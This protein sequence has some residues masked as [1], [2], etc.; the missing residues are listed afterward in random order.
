MSQQRKFA[1]FALAFMAISYFIA[2]HIERDRRE[3]LE[4]RLEQY[5]KTH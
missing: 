1:I 2:Y 4:K 5:E 3:V